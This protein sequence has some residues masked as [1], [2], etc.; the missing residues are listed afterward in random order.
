MGGFA[1]D[2]PVPWRLARDSG[3]ALALAGAASRLDARREVAAARVLVRD[4]RRARLIL[5]DPMAVPDNVL[6]DTLVD[7]GRGLGIDDSLRDGGN[8]GS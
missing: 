8:A 6:G 3:R 7:F 1:A 4:R 5:V 2:P